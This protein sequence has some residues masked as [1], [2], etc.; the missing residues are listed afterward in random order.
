MSGDQLIRVGDTAPGFTLDASD[1][2]AYDLSSVLQHA[3][4]AL[5]FYPGNNTPG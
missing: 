2:R 1:G 3:H 4:V 5:V